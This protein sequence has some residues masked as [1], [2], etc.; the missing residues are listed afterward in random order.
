MM[1]SNRYGIFYCSFKRNPEDSL[2]RDN[3]EFWPVNMNTGT[4]PVY[5]FFVGGTL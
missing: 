1:K 4:S 3:I 5:T 2:F